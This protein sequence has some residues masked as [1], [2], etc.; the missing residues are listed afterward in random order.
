[1]VPDL[2]ADLEAMLK[3]IGLGHLSYL[4]E[5][6]LT[7]SR[8]G[9]GAD[10]NRL[11]AA[12]ALA[13]LI[14]RNARWLATF[15]RISILMSQALDAL[16]LGA[17]PDAVRFKALYWLVRFEGYPVKEAWRMHRSDQESVAI[18]ALLNKPVET[19]ETSSST[20]ERWR[21]DLERWIVAETDFML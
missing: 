2:F 3:P 6:Q 15:E 19:C 11:A 4:G 7:K 16:D 20:L 12:S 8:P 10:Y 21:Q 18:G 9:I 5:W 13:R 17:A 1:M 14:L